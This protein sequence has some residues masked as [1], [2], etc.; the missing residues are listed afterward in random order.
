MGRTFSVVTME[1]AMHH[2]EPEM[3][4]ELLAVGAPVTTLALGEACRRNHVH[5]MRHV[6]KENLIPKTVV[7]RVLLE[8]TLSGKRT[9]RMLAFLLGYSW[10]K[11]EDIIIEAIKAKNR[12]EV[13][14]LLYCGCPWSTHSALAVVAAADR[15]SLYLLAKADSTR[16]DIEL[17]KADSTRIDI[18]ACL[19]EAQ[20]YVHECII[21]T[22]KWLKLP[23]L[24]GY[25]NPVM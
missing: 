11:S 23:E 2:G 20:R 12:Y 18:G 9:D 10:P 17:A 1:I 21:D 24:I 8:Y 14:A 25:P 6:M 16:I 5:V 4:K 7:L 13:H 19:I 15:R 3:V 22:I